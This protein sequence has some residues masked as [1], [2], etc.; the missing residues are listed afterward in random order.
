MQNFLRRSLVAAGFAAGTALQIASAQAQYVQTAVCGSSGCTCRV[1]NVTIEE[2]E[3]T[4]RLPTRDGA[5]DMILV[6]DDVG[7]SWQ[8]LTPAQLDRK[9]GGDGSCLLELTD[10]S[11]M[12]DGRWQISVGTTDLSACKMVGGQIAAGGMTGETRTINWGREFHPDTLFMESVGMVRWSKTGLQTWRGV[13]VDERMSA[14]GGSSGASVIHSIRVDSS[15][16]VSGN[17]VFEY[18]LNIPGLD[19]AAASV[20]AGM[21]C[22]TVTPFTARK[23]G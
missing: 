2:V 5:I 12:E 17:T 20:I 21:Q 6:E 3:A 7:F 9:Y 10:N 16:Q 23:I 19:A 8:D 22:K 13:V 15:T 4:L 11:G 1:S 18:D 14:N